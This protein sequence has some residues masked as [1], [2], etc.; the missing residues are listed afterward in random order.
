MSR[1][2]AVVG[3]EA[4]IAP[5]VRVVR[6][7]GLKV[8]PL[9]KGKKR[10]PTSIRVVVLAARAPG[11]RTRMMRDWVKT[12]PGNL[13]IEATGATHAEA[14]LRA[15]FPP[16]LPAPPADPAPAL[17]RDLV[18]SQPP[19]P[20]KEAPVTFANS[21]TSTPASTPAS[22]PSTASTPAG[23]RGGHGLKAWKIAGCW[24]RNLTER[25]VKAI[26]RLIE[27]PAIN[28]RRLGLSGPTGASVKRGV[29]SAR[30]LSNPKL[31][32]TTSA[33]T[34][35]LMQR[36]ELTPCEVRLVLAEPATDWESI[37]TM[38]VLDSA[39]R[40]VS[41]STADGASAAQGGSDRE[42]ANRRDE[43]MAGIL[44]LLESGG[45]TVVTSSSLS[46]QLAQCGV[47][48]AP[49]GLGQYLRVWENNGASGFSVAEVGKTTAGAVKW[50]LTPPQGASA[51]TS[52]PPASVHL[53]TSFFDGERRK[54]RP[55]ALVTTRRTTTVKC[56]AVVPTDEALVK[57]LRDAG[58]DMAE[59]AILTDLRW[60]TEGGITVAWTEES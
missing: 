7:L 11:G 8:F 16:A 55:V 58:M 33:E 13:L 53:P 57:L 37:K 25:R 34:R 26:Q 36:T 5:L 19:T 56:E 12:H 18:L 50:L 32:S 6:S 23:T 2:I 10:V 4:G 46:T 49:R 59:G 35:H 29:R 15:L 21:S 54:A 30:G 45:E 14:A 47:P 28:S 31:R 44:L 3:T 24:R 43:V 39:G 60:N 22:T 48:V 38:A 42:R 52:T 27:D 51:P 41:L 20:P 40:I 1:A 9:S 17:L